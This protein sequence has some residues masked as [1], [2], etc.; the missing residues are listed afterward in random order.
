MMRIAVI[1]NYLSTNLGDDMYIE[2]LRRRYPQHQIFPQH[3]LRSDTRPHLLIYG[4]GGVLSK[5]EGRWDLL[6]EWRKKYHCPYCVVSVGSRVGEEL[7]FDEP[8][9]PDAL[10]VSVRDEA[11]FEAIPGSILIPDL[12]WAFEPP[13][14]KTKY[15]N[16][17]TGI[18]LRHS[19][20]YDSFHLVERV[21]EELATL[22][23]HYIFFSTYGERLGDRTLAHA[24][25]AGFP[26]TFT[27]YT[28]S[29]PVEYLEYYRSCRRVLAMP[30]H[31]I[32][33]AAIYGVPWAT[34]SYSTK[35]D[36]M[37]RDLNAEVPTSLDD[38][39]TW[40]ET[41]RELV[42]TLREEAQQHFSLL[43]PHLM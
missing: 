12:A 24:T 32:I 28:G 23:D 14:A 2:I 20:R 43:D 6:H 19:P 40:N 10:F 17:G 13:K 35:T 22:D 11:S 9:F 36:W 4:G 37:I 18:M 16:H 38:D 33:F 3:Q 39:L 8:P 27:L 41:P 7:S 26:S 15:K 25:R 30:L 31:G 1:G 21:R 29:N 34:W 42:K 5:K